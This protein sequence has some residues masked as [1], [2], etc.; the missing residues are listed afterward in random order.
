MAFKGR[1]TPPPPRDTPGGVQGSCQA[2]PDGCQGL[3]WASRDPPVT[4]NRPPRPANSLPSLPSG[5]QRLPKRTNKSRACPLTP[6]G[7]CH[8][9]VQGS[10][11]GPSASPAYRTCLVRTGRYHF[12]PVAL[13][14]DL[15]DASLRRITRSMVGTF[16]L[17]V[18]RVAGAPAA[19]MQS[20]R[21]PL[22]S[23]SARLG[24]AM[25]YSAR[26]APA[27]KVDRLCVLSWGNKLGPRRPGQCGRWRARPAH[28]R[29]GRH[30]AAAARLGWPWWGTPVSAR[31]QGRGER[32]SAQ[33]PGR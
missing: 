3:P 28:R 1:S 30:M 5:F 31:P 8:L 10:V 33:V 24:T 4:S 15:A 6:P 7:R 29:E 32:A 9:R 13:R 26:A 27:S 2:M 21:A 17:C 12:A 18:L 25:L 11:S 23:F 19:A 16:A 14:G 20:H 22:L